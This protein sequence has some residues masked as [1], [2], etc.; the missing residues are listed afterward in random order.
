NMAYHPKVLGFG[1]LAPLAIALQI[2][3]L[4]WSSRFLTD[5]KIPAEA[6]PR[7]LAGFAECS[8]ELRTKFA[9]RRAAKCIEWPAMMVR[10]GLWDEIPNQG[11][12][13]H[14]YLQ[15]NPSRAQVLAARE[16]ARER[17]HRVRNS[18]QNVQPN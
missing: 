18:S 16:A 5:G 17:M 14:D 3:A 4:C 13:I 6:I 8:R 7:L 11:Y 12:M 9:T 15:Y 1:Q 10:A 2:R